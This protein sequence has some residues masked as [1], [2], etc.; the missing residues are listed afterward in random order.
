MWEK[1]INSE[2][3]AFKT[4]NLDEL[5]ELRLMNRVDRK[6]V[7]PLN[8]LPELLG[9]VS[10][11]YQVLEIKG[12]RCLLYQTEYLDSPELDFYHNHQNQRLNRFKVRFRTY[13]I[14]NN[15]FFE[16]KRK[17]NKGKTIKKRIEILEEEKPEIDYSFLNSVVPLDNQYLRPS[18]SNRFKRITLASFKS[19]ERITLDFDLE[20]KDQ[21]A[22]KA[23]PFL[24]IAELKREKAANNSPCALALKAMNIYPRG[25]SKYCMG[26][27]LLNPCLK[28][29]AFK[30]N[31]L[32]LKK[33]KN[34]FTD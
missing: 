9:R 23:L 22:Q 5:N 16:I 25:F 26:K 4:I 2:L 17:T 11:N 28:Q 29:N 24:A 27:A 20:I 7:F 18:L 19:N 15:T 12:E 6:F 1:K 10:T 8:K 32:Y 13:T 3:Q 14:S 30:P 21:N 34:E 31:L 33:I